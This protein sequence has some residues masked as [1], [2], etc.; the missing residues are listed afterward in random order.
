MRLGAEMFQNGVLWLI[1]GA[2]LLVIEVLAPGAFMMWL[3]IAAL[4]TGA[5]TLA[6]DPPLWAQVVV[7]AVLAGIAL[8]A[9]LRLKA[10]RKAPMLNN[11]QAG[12]VGRQAKVL[13][14]DGGLLRVRIGDSD[15][16]ARLA[17]GTPPP[18]SGTV[19]RVVG[20]DGTIVVVESAG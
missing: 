14:T 19:L 18:D 13:T 4:G 20:V 1:A 15:W 6:F 5:L 3:G 17:S 16:T 2:V 10:A 11:A 12:L 8:A 7:F 9:G